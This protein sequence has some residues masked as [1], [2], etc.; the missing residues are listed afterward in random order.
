MKHGKMPVEIVN[1][2][3]LRCIGITERLDALQLNF[4][5]A[6]QNR[7]LLMFLRLYF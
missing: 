3:T 1:C 6:L 2:R 5:L 4:C 7:Q